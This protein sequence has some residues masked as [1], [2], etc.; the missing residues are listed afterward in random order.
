MTEP[1]NH[2]SWLPSELSS[3]ILE[4]VI[5]TDNLVPRR[6]CKNWNLVITGS[7]LGALRNI[8]YRLKTNP[9][10][11]PIDLKDLIQGA[12]KLSE[13]RSRNYKVFFKAFVTGIEKSH[14]IKV[15]FPFSEAAYNRVQAEAQMLDESLVSIWPKIYAQLHLPLPRKDADEIR[16]YL[17]DPLNNGLLNRITNLNLDNM[18][19][20]ILPPEIR[21]FRALTSLKLEE[22]L[23]D[24]L[25]DAIGDLSSLKEFDLPTN[26]LH[27]IP[28]TIG[29]LKR[30]KCL[31]LTNNCLDSL[32]KEIG[33]LRSLGELH[34]DKN[35]LSTLPETIGNLKSLKWLFLENNH[36]S[37]L[38][39]DI[40]NLSALKKLSIEQNPL[41]FIPE[42]ILSS[43]HY[44]LFS[45]TTIKQFKR[46]LNFSSSFP[47]AKLYQAIMRRTNLEEIR[48]GFDCLFL[49]DKYL[50]FGMVFHVSG[51]PQ[52]EDLQWGEHHLFDDMDI[53]YRSV[54]EMIIKKYEDLNPEVK[55]RVESAIYQLAGRPP[56]TDRQWGKSHALEN[57][58]RLADTMH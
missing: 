20:K 21:N 57:L 34:L 1:S 25:P 44:A 32:P 53:F 22:N 41:L 49:E 50:V 13:D 23:L 17:N 26:Q 42:E 5:A 55:K 45:N 3:K 18:E 2:F 46:E 12:E 9:P 7:D 52:T 39:K 58:P 6:V 47:L 51:S 29:N 37:S 33:N 10:E 35:R 36:L 11:G 27:S 4:Y 15:N 56:T 48:N 38:P 8:W 40:R 28:K 54:R 24:S 14:S 30:L 43:S 31:N 16:C 19:L